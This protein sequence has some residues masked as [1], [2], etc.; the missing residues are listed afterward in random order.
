MCISAVQCI[1]VGWL[2][3]QVAASFRGVY[4]LRLQPS[5]YIES[6]LVAVVLTVPLATAECVWLY[7]FKHRWP[8]IPVPDVTT[9]I[10]TDAERREL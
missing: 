5:D 1:V 8:A 4:G 7:F 3:T 2:V 10:A 9:E 6:A